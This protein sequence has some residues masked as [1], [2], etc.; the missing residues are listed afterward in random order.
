MS[1]SDGPDWVFKQFDIFS[2]RAMELTSR[3]LHSTRSVTEAA[4]ED[5]LAPHIQLRYPSRSNIEVPEMFHRVLPV[6]ILCQVEGRLFNMRL[7]GMI[8]CLSEE[9]SHGRLNYVN[10]ASE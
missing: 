2:G 10:Y 6:A 8:E 1:E 9:S 4:Q 7:A 3:D 5:T